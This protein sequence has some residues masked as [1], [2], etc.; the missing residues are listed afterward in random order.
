MPERFSLRDLMEPSL[1]DSPDL[2]VDIQVT[3]DDVFDNFAIE[4]FENP[5][6]PG[7]ALRDQ[8]VLVGIV[9]RKRLLELAGSFRTRETLEMAGTPQTRAVYF[10]CPQKKCQYRELVVFYDPSS[11]PKCP[12]HQVTLEKGG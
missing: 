3:L 9:T 7:V 8:G 2:V 1:P 11:P 4:L 10:A 6:L 5:D 12:R